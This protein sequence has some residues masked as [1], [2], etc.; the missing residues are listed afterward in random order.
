[1]QKAGQQ[2]RPVIPQTEKEAGHDNV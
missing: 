2:Y 1:M